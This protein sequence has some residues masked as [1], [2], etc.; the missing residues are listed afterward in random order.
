[1]AVVV[2]NL[3]VTRL[4]HVEDGLLKAKGGVWLVQGVNIP[5]R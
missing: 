5:G 4:S 1:M 3:S 2:D